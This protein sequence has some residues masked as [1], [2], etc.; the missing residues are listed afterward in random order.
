MF[1][2]SCWFLFL[3]SLCKWPNAC[4]HVIDILKKT[5]VE[6]TFLSDLKR[7]HWV[8]AEHAS[9]LK[10]VVRTSDLSILQYLHSYPTGRN[11]T[12]S[13]PDMIVALLELYV[14]ALKDPYFAKK[15]PERKLLFT[16]TAK[17]YHVFHNILLQSSLSNQTMLLLQQK[18]W[19]S[20]SVIEPVFAWK[21]SPSMFLSVHEICVSYVNSGKKRFKGFKL[22]KTI[23][24]NF[25]VLI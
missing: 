9:H 13:K 24:D 12:F 2:F 18:Y 25:W 21:R 15:C 7:H 11:F 20:A 16:D 19:I 22:E 1:N 14:W 10:W 8:L 4:H 23:Y 3:T 17:K 6:K 5:S